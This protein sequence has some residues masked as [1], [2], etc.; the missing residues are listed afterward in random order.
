MLIIFDGYA[1][2]GVLPIAFFD[3]IARYVRAVPP[4][5]RCCCR[6]SHYASNTSIWRT[7]LDFVLPA[8]PVGRHR[9]PFLTRT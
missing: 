6:R 5:A 8:E 9:K 4:P 3:S 1:R 7:P 2:Q